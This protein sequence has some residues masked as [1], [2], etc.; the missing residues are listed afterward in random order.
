MY[1]RSGHMP[2][3]P[4]TPI[5]APIHTYL[6]PLRQYMGRGEDRGSYGGGGGENYGY[7]GGL[8]L[9]QPSMSR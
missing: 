7:G 6:Q 1:G 5:H 9:P 4:H 8:L 2:L 3:H